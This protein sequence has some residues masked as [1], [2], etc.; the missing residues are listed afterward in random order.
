M[1]QGPNGRRLIWVRHATAVPVSAPCWR[2]SITTAAV[3]DLAVVNGRVSRGSGSDVPGLDPF[4]CRY[5][6]RNQLFANEGNGRFRDISQHNAPFCG[7]P[8]VA[9]G[10][11][12]GDLGNRGAVDLIVTAVAAPARVYRNAV[13]N[14]GHWLGLRAFDPEFRR[15]AYGAEI[16]VYAGERRWLRWVSPGSSYLCSNDPRAH[17]GLGTVE[18]VDRIEVVWPDGKTETFDGGAV[19]RHG[20]LA[21]GKG[22]GWGRPLSQ[23]AGRTWAA[24]IV[25]SPGGAAVG[26]QG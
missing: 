26:S 10:L 7:T 13:P 3:W 21:K 8:S 16:T 12:Y 25:V 14:R 4:W 17:F 15:D 18:R 19:D 6:E 5:A 24:R 9:R 23:P 11:A 2:T 22:P 1:F 20:V